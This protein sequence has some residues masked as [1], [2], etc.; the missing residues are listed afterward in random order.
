MSGRVEFG[1]ND[2]VPDVEIEGRGRT[3]PAYLATPSGEGPWPGVVVLHD[4]V[5][6]SS[7]LQRQADWLAGAGYLAVAPDL[8]AGRSRLACTVRAMRDVVRGQGRAFEDVDAARTFLRDREDCTGKLGVIGFCFGG[9]FAIVLAPTGRFDAASVNYGGLPKDADV[10]LKTSCP[11]VGSFG[12]LDRTQRG[13]A[14]QLAS[15]LTEHGIPHDVHEYPDANHA[16]MNDHDRSEVPWVFLLIS[17]LFPGM[18]F[19][20]P[21]DTDARRRILAFFEQYLAK[22]P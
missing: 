14:A 4:A 22:A 2:V 5:G 19:H 10:L 12:R 9:G 7:D 17:R 16:F 6:M 8:F 18:D 1:D 11:I 13:D 3:V 20:E 21:S 15:I